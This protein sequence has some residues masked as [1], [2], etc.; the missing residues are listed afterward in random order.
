VTNLYPW[1]GGEG[2]ANWAPGQPNQPELIT[3][4]ARPGPTCPP[5]DPNIYICVCSAT[6]CQLELITTTTPAPPTCPPFDPNQYICVC[7]ATLCQLELL[8]TTT[9]PG[10]TCPPYDPSMYI[11]LCGVS[12][13][14][15]E[16]ISTTAP[17]AP[18]DEDCMEMN[19]GLGWNDDVC[20]KL[21]DAICER[22]P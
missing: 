11:C 8:T 16:L 14:S 1:G 6:L 5:Y 13:C 20:T 22:Q 7:S 4:T 19:Y 9:R 17:P 2:Y 15:L 10:P 21:N 18:T 3:T 12:S